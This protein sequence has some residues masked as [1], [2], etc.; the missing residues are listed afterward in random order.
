VLR[1]IS[2]NLEQRR[3]GPRK[4]EPARRKNKGWILCGYASSII[5]SPNLPLKK[6]DIQ[7]AAVTPGS[8]PGT[9]GNYYRTLRPDY[10]EGNAA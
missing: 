5:S 9:R 3:R 7:W 8:S 2:A 1:R 10:W 6:L 4:T